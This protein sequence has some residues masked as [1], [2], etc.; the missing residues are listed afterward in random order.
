M[1]TILLSTDDPLAIPAAIE[2]IQQ[3]GLI[4]FPTDTVYGLA[5]DFR[6]EN[7]IA[8]LFEAKGRDMNKA[9]AV[10]VGDVEQLEAVTTDFSPCAQRLA[11]RF[12]P[13]ALTMVVTKRP[14][15]PGLLSVL[16]TI[17]VRIP[18]HSFALHLLR[19]GG[20]LAV[21]SA[22]RSGAE[23]PLTA[24]EVMEQLE[25]RVDLVLDGGRCQ[26]GVP[27][28]VVDCTIPDAKILRQGAISAEAIREI[29]GEG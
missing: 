12:W 21:T 26:G 15:L 16:P 28:T 19:A 7:A 5:A 10:L 20:P 9:I 24:G 14:E 11:A 1:E 17:G 3:G 8:R 25:G 13:G 22:N 29:L 4:A 2:I 6:N 23:N 27:S 18:D